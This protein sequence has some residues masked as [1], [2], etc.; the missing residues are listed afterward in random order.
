MSSELKLDARYW[1]R[2]DG[3]QRTE[4]RRRRAEGVDFRI[5]LSGNLLDFLDIGCLF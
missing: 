3:G 1:M 4:D 5:F 2:D